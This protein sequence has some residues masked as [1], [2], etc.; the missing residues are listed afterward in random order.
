MLQFKCNCALSL[1]QLYNGFRALKVAP[2][3]VGEVS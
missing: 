1:N 3:V 2:R